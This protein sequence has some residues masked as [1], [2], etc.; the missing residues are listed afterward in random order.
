MHARW[1]RSRRIGTGRRWRG[2]LAITVALLL[3]L[4]V[5]VPPGA[6]PERGGFPSPFSWLFPGLGESGPQ[7]W[8]GDAFK[9]LPRQR[10]GDPRSA[11]HYVDA[12]ATAAGRG[13]GRA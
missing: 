13:A 12:Q 4:T 2:K 6:V 3:G 5:M 8:P 11:G 1:D 10:S 9:G 7:T